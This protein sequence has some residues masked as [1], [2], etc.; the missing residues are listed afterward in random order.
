MAAA[1]QRPVRPQKRLRANSLPSI[2]PAPGTPARCI[3][4]LRAQHARSAR[5]HTPAHVR[6]HT[7][8]RTCERSRSHTQCTDA[9]VSGAHVRVSFVAR[10]P[11]STR[12]VLALFTDFQQA[13]LR[14][15]STVHAAR[16]ENIRSMRHP[17]TFELLKCRVCARSRGRRHAR[18]SGFHQIEADVLLI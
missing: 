6:A 5:H 11:C 4:G 12:G 13:R 8:A 7:C 2:W 10:F 15:S 18:C 3:I 16:V 17:S 14:R 1:G 9:C